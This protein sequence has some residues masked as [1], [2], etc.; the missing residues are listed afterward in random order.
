M[1][2]RYLRIL[3]IA[4]LT[5]SLV[6]PLSMGTTY[7]QALVAQ[8][9]TQASG[10]IAGSIKDVSG[11]P[12]AGATVRISGPQTQ[13]AT[14]DAQGNFS[15][16]NL[17][18]GIYSFRSSK[19]GYNTATESNITVLAGTTQ[20]LAVTMAALSFNTLR[21]IANVR[22]AGRGTFNTTPASVSVVTSQTFQ[23]QAQPQVMKVLNETPGV[24]ASLPQ[25]SAN[26]QAPGAITFPNIRGALSFESASLI[27]GHPVSVGSFGDYVT[28]FLNPFMLQ[29]IELVKGPGADAP[30]VN[31]AIGG[32]INFNTKEP[33]YLPA[34]EWQ[35]GTD[36]YG[37]AIINFGVT[38]T[39]GRLG[40]VFAYGT[41]DLQSK[42]SNASV[43]VS[44]QTPQQG[45][46]GYNNGA[47]SSVGFNDGFPTPFVPGTISTNTNQYNLVACCQN[48]GSDLF[49][50]N[51]ELVKL[52]YKLSG[53]TTATFTY[54]GSQT[55]TNQAA[56]TGDITHS[57]FSLTGSGATPGQIASYG[58]SIPNNSALDVGFVR[59]PE[60][61]I[62]NEPILEGDLRTSLGNDTILGRYYS[63]GIHRL[64]YQGSGHPN[65]PTVLDM[66]LYGYDTTTK[67]IYNGQ[68]LPVTFFD[69]FSQAE[70]DVLQGYTLE[71]NHPLNANNS[72]TFAYDTTDSSTVSWSQGASSV[73]TGHVYTAAAPYVP[74][75]TESV[76]LPKGSGQIFSTA[77]LRANLHPSSKLSIIFT[78]YLNSY[79][80]TVPT[81]C[82]AIA[83]PYNGHCTHL[84]TGVTSTFAPAPGYV[85]HTYNSSH[86]DPRLAVEFRPSSQTALRLAV[87]SS[88][89]PPYLAEITTVPGAIT[90]SS[91]TGIA[92]Q[93]LQ[94][95]SLLPETSFGY[96][97][98]GD[99][100]FRDGVTTITGD[101]YM[102]N[103]F[104]HFLTSLYP[105]GAV[106]PA[107]DPNTGKA[108]PS[109]CA[110]N[111]LFYK[112]NIN[113]AN[114]RYEGIELGIRRV[115]PEGFGYTLQGALQKGYAYN[116][117]PC[118]YGSVKLSN[119]TTA[120][121][122]TTNLAIIPGANFYGGGINGV[123]SVNGVNN[124]TVG[125]NG[126]SNQ[127]VPYS[128]GYGE[129]N[130][131]VR[132]W[133]GNV[134][135][136]YYGSN[137]SLNE[138]AFAV[139]GATLRAPLASGLSLQV[140]GDNLGNKYADLW[141]AFGAGVAVPL[142]NGQLAATQANV[143][144][145]RTFRVLLTKTF[146]PGAN[147][148]GT[149]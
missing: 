49:Q 27:D 73:S 35:V 110:G 100:R 145:A 111:P 116:L 101:V 13:A 107:I 140:S 108:T 67:Q 146:G 87:G 89:A 138:P 125:V 58:G 41:D 134:N 43:F 61:E 98:G 23:D 32:T 99:Y 123:T 38:G 115:P 135:A 90:Y 75:L 121:A 18:T 149:P 136:T 1:L 5:A 92:T 131:R 6:G 124:V 21:T 78:N 97:L 118:F 54:L 10:T 44:P 53:V 117:A 15:I 74:S 77:M 86:F 4:L 24:V 129:L 59:T 11:A 46:L 42:L 7:A 45:I 51:S 36:N 3:S 26:A 139:Y 85:F 93:Q 143:L 105:S 106:C 148:N 142:A 147:P 102:T 17:P 55:F 8:G 79:K 80:S 9:A 25:T 66:Q 20:T 48:V 40:Y 133:Y 16:A 72:L 19:A 2:K 76:T 71:W 103:L 47:G 30:E 91:Q 56:N 37:S 120:C 28:T 12:I 114:T 52:R 141:P 81:Q 70:D 144:P 14:T 112:Q 39:D 104:N 22:S 122:F 96:D 63:A 33:T 126:F 82:L 137:N 132:G 64:L 34:G 31:Y 50:N 130:Y 69:Y 62:N 95:S 119:G 57:T 109:G 84:G 29:N 83:L 128:Q 127:N 60:N 113:V 68:T 88:I 65:I 94:S